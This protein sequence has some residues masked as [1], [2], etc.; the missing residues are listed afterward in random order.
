MKRLL[1]YLLMRRFDRDL[2]AEIQAHIDE[3][4]DAYTADGMP[5]KEAQAR[6]SCEFGN[7][8]RVVENCRE[9]W[10][11]ALLDQFTADFR[12]ALRVLRHSP[13]FAFIAIFCLALGIGVNTVAFSAVDHVLLRPLPYP[14]SQQLVSVWGHKQSSGSEQLFVSP[15]DFY[16]WR[17][18]S[19]SF[20]SLAA[21]STWPMNLTNVEN[22]RKLHTEL[23]SANVFTLLRVQPERGRIFRENEDSP[24]AEPVVMLSD[25]L[26]RSLSEPKM[27]GRLTLNGS[28]YTVI[29]VMPA[30]FSFP[31]LDVEAWVPLSLSAENR[32]NRDARWL[33][34]VGRLREH[35]T[36]SGA[37]SEMKLIADQLAQTYPATNMHWSVSLVPLRDEV[38]GKT[39]TVLWTLQIGTLLL[40]LVTCANLANLLL[41]RGASRTRE[42]GMRTALGA[43]RGRI[44][45]QFLVE[46]FV[47][48]LAGG[49]LGLAMAEVGITI[50]RTLSE[51]LLPRAAEIS[52]S[53][54]VLFGAL[55][56]SA[57]TSILF[58][59][60]P[61][62]SASHMDLRNEIAV[63]SRGTLRSAEKKRGLLVTV[64]L[65]TAVVLLIGAALLCGSAIRLIST[66]TGLRVDTVLTAALSLPHSQYPTTAAQNALLERVLEALRNLPGVTSSA[67]ISDTPLA[68]NNPTLAIVSEEDA[69]QQSDAKLR[70][71][72]RVVSPTY[73]ATAGIPVLR[74][75]VFGV[76]D[77]TDTPLV[78]VVNETM[79]RRVWGR[80]NAVTRRIRMEENNRWMTVIGVVRDV[81][82]VGLKAEEGPVL[83]IPYSQNTQA[84]MSWTTL[85]IRTGLTPAAILPSLRK[86]IHTIDK[87]LPLEQ[88]E[89]LEQ[90]VSRATAIPRFVA[91]TAG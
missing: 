1:R 69:T 2:D 8:T 73:F 43:S 33:Q 38:I 80:G 12:F 21:F 5:S 30:N 19:R 71:G 45:R 48:A 62:L 88:A 91:G 58:G 14:E 85:V 6:A 17:A 60:A 20:S 81:K 55:A 40:L 67:A 49:G 4:A 70:A 29:G 15:A 72:F 28:G 11:T 84:W 23:V 39:G 7:R 56:V 13:L 44:M 74:G 77:Q 27:G 46:S 25:R 47:L 78:A 89:T 75:R 24:D 57:I 66:P 76:T 10:G 50:I 53:A 9:T 54:P 59:V 41:A 31:S 86:T 79:A 90:I 36:A 16:D 22:P 87:N 64:E 35:A 61:A 3:K 18:R 63:G 52:L 83:Y 42:V 37:Q 51:S 32:T 26:W 34:V 68:G 65:S 82:Q